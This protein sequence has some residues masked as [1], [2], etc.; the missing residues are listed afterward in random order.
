M[1][2][3]KLTAVKALPGWLLLADFADGRQTA[4]NVGALFDVQPEFQDLRNIPGLFEQVKVDV[5]GHGVSWN[6]A[7][8]LDA[9]ELYCNGLETRPTTETSRGQCCPACGQMIRRKS[10][11][12][13]A[14]SRVIGRKGGRPKNVTA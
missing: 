2:F 3:H 4:Y 10:S 14:A 8:D 9:E 5:G 6:D 12:Q 1:A 13:T 7:I 11:R